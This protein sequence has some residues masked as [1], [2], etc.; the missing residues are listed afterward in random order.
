M[1]IIKKQKQFSKA[2]QDFQLHT[3]HKNQPITFFSVS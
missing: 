1:I 3:E 2:F